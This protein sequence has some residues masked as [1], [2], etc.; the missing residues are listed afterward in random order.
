MKYNKVDEKIRRNFNLPIF[1]DD[2]INKNI[3][4]TGES[5]S[6]Y[7]SRLV[8]R[9]N[10]EFKELDSIEKQLEDLELTYRIESKR[11]EI[12][13]NNIKK[14]IEKT[15]D[16]Y[17]KEKN[18]L[19]EIKDKILNIDIPNSIDK[20]ILKYVIRILIRNKIKLNKGD[21]EMNELISGFAI[22]NGLS[23]SFLETE[24]L[25]KLNIFNNLASQEKHWVIYSIE[26]MSLGADGN[27]ENFFT[28]PGDI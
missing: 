9:D 18:K 11:N 17:N 16:K 14:T 10:K 6:S 2:T 7:L 28:L 22:N 12:D 8:L 27:I 3:S 26:N 1:I 25:K 19:T 5:K 24:Y 4:E 15:N 20:N 21:E 13:L 23:K